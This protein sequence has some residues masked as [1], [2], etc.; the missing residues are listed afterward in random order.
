MRLWIEI[1][2]I[3]DSQN[4]YLR[5]NSSLH[6]S[7]SSFIYLP[8]KSALLI[9]TSLREVPL[10]AS[11]NPSLKSPRF[12][13]FYWDQNKPSRHLQEGSKPPLCNRS[14][15]KIDNK[16]FYL[17]I[18]LSI[19]FFILISWDITK[20]TSLIVTSLIVCYSCV[21]CLIY[22]SL[23]IANLGMYKGVEAEDNPPV[24]ET[25]G[26]SQRGLQ[27]Q[28]FNKFNIFN[29]EVH[30]TYPVKILYLGPSKNQNHTDHPGTQISY[31]KV[32]FPL[33]QGHYHLK[34][35]R[36]PISHYYLLFF[37]SFFVFLKEQ[38]NFNICV[39]TGTSKTLKNKG[40]IFLGGFWG[41]YRFWIILR[42]LYKEECTIR[43]KRRKIRM[44]LQARVFR[45]PSKAKNWRGWWELYL[46]I[47]P[48][49]KIL[50]QKNQGLWKV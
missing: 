3:C 34:L 2:K 18:I 15:W 4:Q 30:P 45:V 46:I 7:F 28:M 11:N 17:I 31:C 41:F 20:K 39:K 48:E 13:Y 33:I 35:S 47:R 36:F 8:Q 44:F 10:M 24:E 9:S 1:R 42:Y 22:S 25:P 14:F 21:E 43:N 12:L 5:G 29:F 26:N 23:S 6:I 40:Y 50:K 16:I 32:I 49:M 19:L 38:I 27:E 37:A